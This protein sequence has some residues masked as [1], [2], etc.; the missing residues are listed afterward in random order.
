MIEQHKREKIEVYLDQ[1]NYEQLVALLTE[2]LEE[3]PGEL[4]YYWYLGLAYL[5]QEEIEATQE[6]W[7]SAFLR[8][9]PDDIE[10]WTTDLIQLLE[11]QIKKYLKREKIGNAKLIYD[12]INL[13]N[14]E[15]NNPEILNKIVEELSVLAI[16]LT[17]K[18]QYE[19]AIDIYQEILSLDSND[20]K[21]LHSLALCYYNLERYTKAKELITKAIEL[22]DSMANNYYG[23]GLI[24]EKQENYSSAIKAY[25]Q[26]ID[27]GLDL[28]DVYYKLA[29]LYIQDKLNDKALEVY[30]IAFKKRWNHNESELLFRIG[31]LYTVQGDPIADRILGYAAFFS[32]DSESAIN[33]FEKYL[34]NQK[35]DIS[36]YLEL[37]RLY[38]RTNQT[39]LAIEFIKQSLELHPNNLSLKSFNVS[40]LPI[41]YKN[42]QEIEFYRDRFTKLL[43]NLT[44]NERPQTIEQVNESSDGIDQKA[45]FYLA[46]QGKN[47]LLL[48][49]QYADYVHSLLKFKYP[50]WCQD[51]SISP[52][53]NSRKIRVGFI[54]LKLNGLGQFYLD[55]LKFCDKDKF[56][57]YV[58]D[59]SGEEGKKPSAFAYQFKIHSQH[60]WYS[61]PGQRLADICQQVASDQLDILIFPEIGL[62]P[63]ITPLSCLRLAPIQCT[64]WAHPV[65]SG[66]PTID[67]FLSSELMEPANGDE[68]Y[69]EKL[70]RLPNIGF[71]INR[72]CLPSPEKQRQ[73][74]GL[75][76]DGILYWCC[77]SLFKYLPQHDYIFSAIAQ[78][79]SRFQFIFLDCYLGPIITEHFK[80]RLDKAFVEF[81]LDYQQY[82][83]FLPRLIQK[84]FVR[85][86]QLAD[87]FLD[88]LSWSGGFTARDAITFALPVV[89]RPSEVMRGRHS[90]GI[91]HMIGVTETIA[92]TESEY[93]EIAV[94]LGLDDQWRQ[95]IRDKIS[96]NSHRLFEDKK[97]ISA[98]ES[99]FIEVVQNQQSIG[100][101]G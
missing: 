11:N 92:Q 27:K 23:L 100:I 101:L 43:A 99:F 3:T 47:D 71:S 28:M 33:H 94:R 7:L 51:K 95:T 54:S 48:Q 60:I 44:N 50:Q 74:F 56:E 40:I 78:H 34:E 90:Y 52:D 67:Y 26:A 6:V 19:A 59:L 89:T 14:S 97:C 29:D 81:G 22:D 86:T 57:T 46:Y 12:A 70:I 96:A 1:N 18:R 30:E 5:L 36:V 66:S 80:K 91:L 85:V 84:E 38:V 72:P 24:L 41:L 76:E 16:G 87:V 83:I 77:Q 79:S 53:L 32:E 42:I 65:T 73:D 15:Y 4:E 88:C 68:H 69:S 37:A 61:L 49:K 58:Y 82:C 98:L 8:G 10:P 62:D 93:I 45:N 2:S 21:I 25:H 17:D 35:N 9:T 63:I 64:T 13:A 39:V 75:R 31:R 55:W 20:S